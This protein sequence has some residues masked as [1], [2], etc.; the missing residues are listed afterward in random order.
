MGKAIVERP[1]CPG[2]PPMPPRP[3]EMTPKS[4]APL[5]SSAA[6]RPWAEN[7]DMIQMAPRTFGL[8]LSGQGLSETSEHTIRQLLA[9]HM[10]GP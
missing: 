2:L 9:Q 3:M 10:A 6:T 1:S 5:V 8:H 7:S 4:V